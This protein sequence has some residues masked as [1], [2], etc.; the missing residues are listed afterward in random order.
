M[1]D[2]AFTPERRKFAETLAIKD[3]AE[4]AKNGVSKAAGYVGGKVTSAAK[5]LWNCA[6]VAAG[7][8][9][10]AS[11]F[12]FIARQAG[13]LGTV[14]ITASVVTAVTSKQGQYV[15]GKT[16]GF[17]VR[18]VDTVARSLIK[19][20]SW[21]PFVGAQAAAKLTTWRHR[22]NNK[23]LDL[24]LAA[25]RS[26]VGAAFLHDGIV[27][28]NARR[29]S[30]P[31]AALLII[32]N[33]LSG[34]YKLVGYVAFAAWLVYKAM[35]STTIGTLSY[36]IGK[37]VDGWLTAGETPARTSAVSSTET[38]AGP[39]LVADALVVLASEEEHAAAA[40]AAELAE[41]DHRTENYVAGVI[42]ANQ[43]KRDIRTRQSAVIADLA[44]KFLDDDKN[45][46]TEGACKAALKGLVLPA[47]K[48]TD[49]SRDKSNKAA[50]EF[51]AA[52]CA[53]SSSGEGAFEMG[54][55]DRDAQLIAVCMNLAIDAMTDAHA[56][57]DPVAA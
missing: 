9:L 42:E 19:V 40:V 23:M 36:N 26:I 11:A 21:I 41:R 45:Y 44:L 39:Q 33:L 54:V 35:N 37:R 15:I 48:A 2:Q 20:I 49:L 13:K 53:A 38:P 34:P 1:A 27:S 47:F 32:R 8:G 24:A 57:V 3:R 29:F 7:R 10:L 56:I 5:A 22:A 4:S 14:G 46:S 6:P 43:G 16:L 17:T 12:S 50:G 28:R 25:K 30:L 52:V 18:A 51:A 55:A 31:Y